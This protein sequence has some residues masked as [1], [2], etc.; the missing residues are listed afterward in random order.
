LLLL[1]LTTKKQGF[2]VCV[3]EWALLKNE[4]EE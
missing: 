1:C 2:N 4:G 3:C